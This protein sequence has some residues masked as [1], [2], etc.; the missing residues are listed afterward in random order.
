VAL[1]VGK[2]NN[3]HLDRGAVSWTD[4]GDL[5]SVKGGFLQVPLDDL[6]GILIGVAHIAGYLVF[7]GTGGPE[8]KRNGFGISRL[9]RE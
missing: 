9:G 8:R 1:V 3:L 4:A 6:M 7:Q 2:L 5:S